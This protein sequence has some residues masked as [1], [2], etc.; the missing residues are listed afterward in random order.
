MTDKRWIEWYGGDRPHSPN[1]RVEVRYRDG[2]TDRG[3]SAFARWWHTGHPSPN[4]IIAYRVVTDQAASD[5]GYVGAAEVSSSPDELAM[6]IE[7]V[8]A[9]GDNWR[10]VDPNDHAKDLRLILSSL[11]S[12]EET[13]RADGEYI[14]AQ[15]DW[16]DRLA[17]LAFDDARECSERGEHR[18]E[19]IAM[20]RHRLHAEQS[21][22]ARSRLKDR[23]T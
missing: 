14:K 20:D 1:T 7:R 18:D 5:G 23:E 10:S 16:H 3:Q 11:A 4:D 17:D 6:A 13:I 22:Q 2:S 19:R 21:D 12:Q 8:T 9:W 15:F